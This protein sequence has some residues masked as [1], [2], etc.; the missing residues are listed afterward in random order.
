MTV[1]HSRDEEPGRDP[2]ALASDPQYVR[3]KIAEA[4]R[5]RA[6]TLRQLV[7]SLFASPTRRESRT[8]EA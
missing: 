2:V 7:A 5:L 6:L 4:H 8:R 3:E 1:D